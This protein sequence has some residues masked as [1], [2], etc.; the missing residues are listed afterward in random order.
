MNCED[1]KCRE[2]S[3]KGLGTVGGNTGW[4]TSRYNVE[5]DFYCQ[6]WSLVVND[7]PLFPEEIRAYEHGPAVPSVS[8]QHQHQYYVHPSDIMGDS[9]MLS[10]SDM[11]FVDVVLAA[12]DGMNG[13]QLENLT[14]SEDPWRSCFNQLTG[15]NSSAVISHDD[16]GR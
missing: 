10:E 5:A 2:S 1:L 9:S 7:K 12:Y 16:M 3:S 8:M 6:A 11:A 14:H 15:I 13:Q 4:H